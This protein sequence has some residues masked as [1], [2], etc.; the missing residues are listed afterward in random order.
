MELTTQSGKADVVE[1]SGNDS[2]VA[3]FAVRPEAM[4]S[5]AMQRLLEEVRCAEFN[6]IPAAGAYDR[7]HNRHN[8]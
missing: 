7:A 3:T 5:A 1:T 6:G 2:L 4:K 8:R